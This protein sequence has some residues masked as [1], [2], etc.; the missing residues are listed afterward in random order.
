MNLI[1][2]FGPCVSFQPLIKCRM[3][4][5]C[6]RIF[7]QKLSVR[8]IYVGSKIQRGPLA[9]EYLLYTYIF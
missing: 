2:K 1:G 7:E 3:Q 5:K 9:N 4:R 6:V 8:V